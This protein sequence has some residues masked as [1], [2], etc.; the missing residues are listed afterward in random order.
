MFQV[1]FPR[2]V[3]VLRLCLCVII[4]VVELFVKFATMVW[5]AKG[6]PS[7]SSLNTTDPPN[8]PSDSKLVVIRLVVR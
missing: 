5:N 6:R 1:L 8:L 4:R 7:D 2:N 3:F